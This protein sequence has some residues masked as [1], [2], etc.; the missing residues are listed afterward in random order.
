VL[1]SAHLGTDLV[2]LAQPGL[3]LR[4]RG[5]NKDYPLPTKLGATKVAAH[6]RRH[7]SL[8]STTSPTSG[9]AIRPGGLA[10]AQR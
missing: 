7:R 9:T 8:S 4:D 5:T 3:I 1:I 2:V 6:R 10:D